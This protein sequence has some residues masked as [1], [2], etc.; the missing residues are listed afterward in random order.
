MAKQSEK[1][2]NKDTEQEDLIVVSDSQQD[3]EIVQP[4][5]PQDH[6]PSLTDSEIDKENRVV[7]PADFDSDIEVP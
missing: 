2:Q 3:P 1:K 6:Q 5:P 4:M 7:S